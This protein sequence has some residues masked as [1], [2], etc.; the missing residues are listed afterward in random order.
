MAVDLIVAVRKRF[1]GQRTVRYVSEIIEVMPP[2]DTDRP[3]VNR[4]FL[5][6]GPDGRAVVA[7]TPSPAMLTRLE[8]AG[9]N[10]HLLDLHRSPGPVGSWR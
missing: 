8:T 3:T 1:D 5:P 7:H 10:P 6:T 4:L 9:F 2:G